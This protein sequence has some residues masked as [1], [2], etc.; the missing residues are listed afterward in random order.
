MKT[1]SLSILIVALLFL[2]L[3]GCADFQAHEERMY[4]TWEVRSAKRSYSS[5]STDIT[6]SYADLRFVFKANHA[7]DIHLH[8]NIYHNTWM[9]QDAQSHHE[10]D[11]DN[12][13]SFVSHTIML[14]SDIPA[15]EILDG[16]GV[17]YN[18]RKKMTFFSEADDNVHYTIVLT[19]VYT[20]TP[21]STSTDPD[22]NGN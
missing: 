7:L 11:A 6:A 21:R 2:N 18:T 16:A 13:N 19:Q 14:D 3:L 22:P 17:Q 20:S 15:V 8:D 1:R 12:C 10:S 4:G 9:L 5:G